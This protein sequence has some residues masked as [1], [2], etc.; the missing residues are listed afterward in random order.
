MFARTIKS[1]GTR[2][3]VAVGLPLAG[4]TAVAAL[5]AVVALL[6][7]TG[8]TAHAAIPASGSGGGGCFVPSG[9]CTF[10]NN[11]ASAD[12][13]SVDSTG[14]IL[15]DAFIN[16][17]DSLTRPGNTTGQFA[18]VAI[19]VV[20]SC[21]NFTPVK[22]AFSQ[23]FTGTVQFGRN[24]STAR[25]TGSA[26]MFDVVSNTTFTATFDVTWQGFGPTTS[27]IDSQHFHAPGFILNTHFH[28]SDRAAEASGT[29]SD[30]TTNFAAAPSLSADLFNS[31]GGSVQLFKA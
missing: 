9:P 2:R 12:F 3:L 31:S 23:D 24:L 29:L 14:C 6:P 15:S 13:S 7:S 21:N 28:G 5:L 26:T 16:G 30:G 1:F 8:R 20:D 10:K 18:F 17:F 11:S 19:V 22:E 4:L 25:V 27:M